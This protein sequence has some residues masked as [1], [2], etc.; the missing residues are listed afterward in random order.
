[1][2]PPSVYLEVRKSTSV[3]PEWYSFGTVPW[4]ASP[5]RAH[6][7]FAG[8][9]SQGLLA[10]MRRPRWTAGGNSGRD[11]SPGAP[12]EPAAA[13]DLARHRA[14]GSALLPQQGLPGHSRTRPAHVE[15]RERRRPEDPRRSRRTPNEEQAFDQEGTCCRAEGRRIQHQSGWSG[16]PGAPGIFRFLGSRRGGTR[17]RPGTGLRHGISAVRAGLV[18]RPRLVTSPPQPPRCAP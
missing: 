2:P 4:H 7:L 8:P 14:G 18:P 1:M 16:F 9:R 17:P 13:R 15:M 12:V 10:P 11:A 5:P 6:L 3:R